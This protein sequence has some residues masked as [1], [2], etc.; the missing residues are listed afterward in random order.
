MNGDVITV[1]AVQ[2]RPT[3]F[4]APTTSD[5]PFEP[6]ATEALGVPPINVI[7]NTPAGE[8]IFNGSDND[9]PAHDSRSQS[10]FSTS[11]ADE[12]SDNEECA[13]SSSCDSSDWDA[14]EQGH[15][16][17]NMRNFRDS[18]ME[19][20][21]FAFEHD[22]MLTGTSKNEDSVAIAAGKVVSSSRASSAS[23]FT[24]NLGVLT[25]M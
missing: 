9:T 13:Q 23:L 16:S 5:T 18:L 7:P 14:E 12:F 19:P 20:E 22:L 11:G 3:S 1:S 24:V 25:V 4:L 17:I 8:Q 6:I 2:D 10:S 15:T 21:R